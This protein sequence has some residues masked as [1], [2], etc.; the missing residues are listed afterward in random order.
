MYRNIRVKRNKD[1]Q[2]FQMEI[3]TVSTKQEGTDTAYYS[4]AADYWQ[5]VTPTIDGMLGWDDPC[6]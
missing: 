2:T 5:N 6:K 1:L 3:I 4:K